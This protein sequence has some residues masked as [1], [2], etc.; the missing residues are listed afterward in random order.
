M[1]EFWDARYKDSA[2]AFGE[3]PNEYF[4]EQISNLK[5]GK[6]LMPAEGE[7]RNAVFAATLGWEV[8]AFDMSSEGKVKAEALAADRGV[9][10]DY[11][12]GELSEIRYPENEFDAIGLIYVHFPPNLRAQYHQQL[13]RYLK[14]GGILILEAFN[15]NH[16]KFNSENPQAGGPKNIEML[17][18]MEELKSDFSNYDIIE[19]EEK[20]VELK[21]GIYHVG[22]SAVVR[23]VGRKKQQ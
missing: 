20:E 16:L 6:L 19:L 18:S 5:P 13:D 9:T 10:I 1:K 3:E 17:F 21:E 11:R 22:Q 2:F 7:G 4:K 23:F 8:W 12:V 15:K 14:P